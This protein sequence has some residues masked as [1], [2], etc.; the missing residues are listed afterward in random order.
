M[1]HMV[2][3]TTIS[4]VNAPRPRGMSNKN[5]INLERLMGLYKKEGQERNEEPNTY[6]SLYLK[7]LHRRRRRTDTR[8]SETNLH[9]VHSELYGVENNALFEALPPKKQK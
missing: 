6:M 2:K 3:Q 5:S 4:N 9:P 7:G 1:H 8:C